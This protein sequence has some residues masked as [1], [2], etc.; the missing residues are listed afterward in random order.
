[1]PKAKEHRRNEVRGI[2]AQFRK[3]G[4]TQRAFAKQE[5]VSLSTPTYWIRRDRLEQEIRGT[6]SL[7]EVAPPGPS[8]PLSSGAFVLDLDGFRLEIPRDVSIEEL[9]RLK[10][11]WA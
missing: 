9:R 3:S 2:L 11:A 10:E 8:S 4:L 6:T 7:V 5:G 1:M